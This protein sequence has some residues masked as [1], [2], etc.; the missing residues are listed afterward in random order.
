[1]ADDALLL[2]HQ[3]RK[4]RTKLAAPTDNPWRAF[5]CRGCFNQ[6]YR[7]RC[8]VCERDIRTDPLTGQKRALN[9]SHRKYCG[10]K[11]SGDAARFPHV[12]DW[13]NSHPT[14]SRANASCA[15][16][17]GLNLGNRGDLRGIVGPAH[18]IAAEVF[19][20]RDWQPATSSGG[21]PIEI[22]RIRRRALVETT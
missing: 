4:C 17:A 10:R 12:Y 21:V 9:R 7:S 5:C 6:F 15:Q 8:V 22:G 3:C 13:N 2:H 19:G 16:L 20:G 1:M 14:K 18:V 11:C